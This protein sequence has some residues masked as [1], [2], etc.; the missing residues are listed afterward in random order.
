MFETVFNERAAHGH[1]F[2]PLVR[3][4]EEFLTHL[5]CRGMGRSCLRVYASRLNQIVRFLKLK[6]LRRVRPIED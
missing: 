5:E 1:R 4:K 3:E 2:M 6:R